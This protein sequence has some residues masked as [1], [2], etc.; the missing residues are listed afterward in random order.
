MHVRTVHTVQ[1][2][3][4]SLSFSFDVP[5]G[6]RIYEGGDGTKCHFGGAVDGRPAG[7]E[8]CKKAGADRTQREKETGQRGSTVK[9]EL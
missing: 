4:S 7:S 9:F 6:R 1:K 3:T 5:G 8:M 2:R